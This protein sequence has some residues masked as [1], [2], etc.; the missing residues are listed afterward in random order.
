MAGA[1]VGS[2]MATLRELQEYYSYEDGLDMLEILT[3]QRYNEW[4]AGESAKHG[5]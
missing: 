4:A 1:L 5:R 3:V 2:G